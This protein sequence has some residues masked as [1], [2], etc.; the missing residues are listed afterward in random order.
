MDCDDVDGDDL[1]E[2]VVTHLSLVGF[3]HYEEEVTYSWVA[4][5]SVIRSQGAS[6]TASLAHDIHHGRTAPEGSNS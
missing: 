2:A 3:Y 4:R 5:E 6:S 1:F